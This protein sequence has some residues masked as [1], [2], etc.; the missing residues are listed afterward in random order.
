MGPSMIWNSEFLVDL[1]EDHVGKTTWEIHP[2]SK[3]TPF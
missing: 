2:I 1:A 3:I